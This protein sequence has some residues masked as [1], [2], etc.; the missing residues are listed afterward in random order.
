[1]KPLEIR[2]VTLNLTPNVGADDGL[3][4]VRV[5]PAGR[6][7]SI[8]YGRTL[9]L[10]EEDPGD[11]I[12]FYPYAGESL[13]FPAGSITVYLRDVD[14][15]SRRGPDGYAALADPMWVWLIAGPQVNQLAFR[16]LFAAARRLDTAHTLNAQLLDALNRSDE[17][18][19]GARQ[20]VFQ[21]L[22]LA[23][24]MCVAIGRVVDML[25]R[26]E[27]LTGLTAVIPPR[28]DASR[29]AVR[30][31]RNA[32]EH[33]EDRAQGTVRGNPH[34]DAL[35]IF[36]QRD[37]LSTGVVRYGPYAID[38]VNELP[39]MILEARRCLLD[40]AVVA[41]GAGRTINRP[42]ESP[43]AESGAYQRVQERAYFLWQNRTGHRWWDDEANWAEAEKTEGDMFRASQ[44]RG[45][46]E[47][48]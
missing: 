10:G 8:V 12:A 42:I 20:R 47:A 29:R 11:A 43:A 3:V 17:N 38:V 18:F 31:I 21:A 13:L 34:P 28:L 1:M 23:E 48:G 35:S 39:P 40:L 7:G 15:V 27:E 6:D 14:L 19:Y 45:S 33:I 22:A 36:D 46:T 24:V 25:L 5:V 44:R 4:A 37:L 9:A 26:A 30:E 16:Y 2:A 32:F 41:A